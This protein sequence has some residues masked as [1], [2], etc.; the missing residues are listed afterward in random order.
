[1]YLNTLL[2]WIIDSSCTLLRWH[3]YG[4]NAQYFGTKVKKLYNQF[5]SMNF[6]QHDKSVWHRISGSP[7]RMFATTLQDVFGILEYDRGLQTFSILPCVFQLK[8][9]E[10][11]E[12]GTEGA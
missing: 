10:P 6:K 4:A 9:E 1:M 3:L 8:L 7:S 5:P 2:R 12:D 11:F